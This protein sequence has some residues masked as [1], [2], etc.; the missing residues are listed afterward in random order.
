MAALGGF[1]GGGGKESRT[2]T[3]NTTIAQEA[4]FSEIS[5]QA[6]SV[7]GDSNQVTLSDFGAISAAR[8]IASESLRQVE[9]AGS[10]TASTVSKAVQ[11]VAE[12][13]RAETENIVIQGAKWAAL[14]VMVFA[15]A[16]ALKGFAG[17]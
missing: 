9:L 2:T 12:S 1:F 6:L 16:W 14:A 13:S 4:G 10:N 7:Q 17:K 8:D 11:A 15:A 3:T 5:G